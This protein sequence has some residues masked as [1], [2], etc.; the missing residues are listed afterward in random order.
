[1][2]EVGRNGTVAPSKTNSGT[3]VEREWL[4]L[5]ELTRYVS[6]SDRTVREWIRRQENP[7]PAVKVGNKVLVRRSQVDTWLESHAIAKE[8]TIAAIVDD[9][10]S[11]IGGQ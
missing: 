1:M 10:M 4:D 7:L 9:V 8:N 11:G 3:A 2:G 5:S 6:A